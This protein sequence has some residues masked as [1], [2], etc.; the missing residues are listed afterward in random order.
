MNA[1]PTNLLPSVR[2]LRFMYADLGIYRYRVAR[3]GRGSAKSHTFAD[4]LV[5][6]G[7]R[8]PLRILCCREI[9]KSIKDSSKKLIED[10]IRAR[11]AQRF[12]V[13]TD[14]SIIGRNGTEFMFEGLRSNP[15]SIKSKEGIDIAWIE[16]ASRAS[17]RSLDILRPTLRKETSE[18][19]ASYNPELPTDPIDSFFRG[20]DDANRKTPFVPPPR[21]RIEEINW[22]D[23][24]FFPKVLREEMEWD[25]RRDPEKYEWVW[26]GQYL[27]NSEARVFKNWTIDTLAI[28]PAWRPY[29]GADWGFSVDPTTLVKVYIIPETRTLYI[30]AELYKVGLEIDHTPAYFDRM[31]NGMARKWP[32]IS[33]S[34][35]PETISYMRRHGYPRIEGAK[36]GAGSVEDGIE[37]MKSFD[38]VVNPK[39]VH[40]IQELTMFSFKIDPLTNQ[41]L[42]V[43]EDKKN[44]VID[45]IR[46]AV[47]ATRR[48]R[49]GMLDVVS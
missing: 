4:A 10:K 13:I 23:N 17:Q 25:R 33:D 44:H 46:Y 28:N 22:Q 40:C 18:L 48:A 5:W 20:N 7:I 31:D 14:N 26:G 36:K 12:Y 42:P 45:G 11:N 39:C 35:R 34:A 19:W 21:T 38:I 3:G 43:L 37:F 32:I 2:K 1:H 15:D 30:A 27:R 29:Y 49:Y 9:Q 8:Q 24:P 16:E 47:E 41:I 6:H